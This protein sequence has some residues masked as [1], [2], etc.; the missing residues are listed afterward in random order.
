MDVTIGD[1]KKLENEFLRKLVEPGV[2]FRTTVTEFKNLKIES[3]KK[4]IAKITT[5][6]K[7]ISK[8]IGNL[9]LEVKSK[10]G[11]T[12]YENWTT[13]V[14]G[15]NYKFNEMFTAENETLFKAITS[16][17]DMI[18]R[19]EGQYL[20]TSKDKDLENILFRMNSFANNIL[21]PYAAVKLQ[22]EKIDELIGF[23]QEELKAIF[24]DEDDFFKL[25]SPGSSNSSKNS[26]EFK[27]NLSNKN[28]PAPGN[29]IKRRNQSPG[30]STKSKY[31]RNALTPIKSNISNKIEKHTMKC[32]VET[33]SQIVGPVHVIDEIGEID[34]SDFNEFLE[35]SI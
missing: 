23:K 34:L 10:T 32:N 21:Q 2:D 28:L 15:L 35:K 11:K 17:K 29:A 25:Q 18:S 9:R 19:K 24:M 27:L 12:F 16:G 7:C 4:E 22:E 6:L 20:N 3:M 14:N 26:G 8:T 13:H 30:K 1:F 5:E 31:Q 33:G